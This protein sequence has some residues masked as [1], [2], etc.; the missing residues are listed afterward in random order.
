MHIRRLTYLEIEI[1]SWKSRYFAAG[2]G[3]R[4]AILMKLDRSSDLLAYMSDEDTVLLS[5]RSNGYL[6]RAMI[7]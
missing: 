3:F 4:R 6:N 2:W 7:R 5:L 1:N